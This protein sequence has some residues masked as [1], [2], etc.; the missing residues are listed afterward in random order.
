MTAC[1]V[2]EAL[3][4]KDFAFSLL[5]RSCE[6]SLGATSAAVT[7]SKHRFAHLST[8]NT[9]LLPNPDNAALR[10]H[11]EIESENL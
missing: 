11:N 7:I 3:A 4:D 2:E 1:H 8:E 9:F 6:S 5:Q 10:G